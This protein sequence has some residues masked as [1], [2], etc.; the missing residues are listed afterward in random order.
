MFITIYTDA[1]FDL[2]K[3]K[4]VAAWWGKC[5]QGTITGSVNI[6]SPDVNHAE[7][8]A[9]L[10]AIEDAIKNFPTIKSIVLKSDNYGCIKSFP[11]SFSQLLVS[12]PPS[13]AAK[14]YWKI[15][16]LL[17]EKEISIVAKHVKAHTDKN[18]KQSIMNRKVDSLTRKKE[19]D[20]I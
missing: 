19:W 17:K 11:Q 8:T 4:G 1:S 5:D 15:A 13:P 3:K 2:K 16:T 6:D 9:I 14:P 7:M 18:D 12:R 20:T 10:L